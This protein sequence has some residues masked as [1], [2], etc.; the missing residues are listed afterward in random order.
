MR[1]IQGYHQ[2]NNP[3]YSLVPRHLATIRVGL[4]CKYSEVYKEQIKH[5]DGQVLLYWMLLPL[6]AP[7]VI[8]MH[9]HIYS[10]I[11]AL[12]NCLSVESG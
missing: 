4:S 11:L 6:C 2:S 7:G 10:H 8:L 1:L 5:G 3:I 9:V 12:L